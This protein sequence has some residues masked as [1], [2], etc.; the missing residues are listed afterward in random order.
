[1]G[2][3]G[4]MVAR[5]LGDEL[6]ASLAITVRDGAVRHP[7]WGGASVL[8]F[9]AVTG[10]IDD[11]LTRLGGVRWVVN[12][13]GTLKPSADGSTASRLNAI[14]VN[15]AFPHRLAEAAERRGVRVLQPA[16]D[17]VFADQVGPFT[18]FDRATATD[19]YGATKSLGEVP[20][21]AMMHLRASIVG[22]EWLTSRSLLAWLLGQPRLATVPGYTDHLWN[23]VTTLHF[24]R[25]VAAVIRH[26]FFEPGVQHLVPA[27]AVTKAELLTALAR[28]FGRGDLMVRP[29]LAPSPADRRLSTKYPERNRLLWAA[30]GHPNLP[31]VSEMC[32]ELAA[33]AVGTCAPSPAPQERL[34][35]QTRSSPSS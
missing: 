20:S 25:V 15:A 5:V 10:D 26:D 35:W 33:F 6:G 24:A 17:G 13:I 8:A 2:M 9:D 21:L 23:G 11:L 32:Q 34:P 12:A 18:E 28:A 7:P 27:A 22:P 16:T 1:M 19:V 14:E 4:G 29:Q 30:A 31:T 3:L